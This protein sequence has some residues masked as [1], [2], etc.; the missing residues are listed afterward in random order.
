VT[1]ETI[2][3]LIDWISAHPDLS[4]VIIFLIAMTESLALVG[5]V[6]P[7]VV[8]MLSIGTLVGLGAIGLWYAI[9]WAILG[10]IAG[11]WFSYWLG[12]HFDQQLRHIWPLSRYPKLIPA[13]EKFFKRHGGKSVL[14]GR[15]V[16]P[17]R[18]I[19]PAIAGIMHMSQPKFYVMNF[20]SAVLWAPVVLLPGVAFGNS[21]QLANEVF[22]KLIIV[23]VILIFLTGILGFI[24]K[25]AFAYALMTTVNTWGEFFG[26]DKARENLASFSVAGLLIL[27]VVL[28]VGQYEYRYQPVASRIETVDYNWWNNN[29]HRFSPVATHYHKFHSEYPLTVQ[30]WGKIEEIKSALQGDQWQES[31]SLKIHNVLNYFLPH[32]DLL[33]LPAR[34]IKLFNGYDKLILVRKT[35]VDGQLMVVRFW[36]ANNGR[37]AGDDQLWLGTVYFLDLASPFGLFKFPLH[38]PNYAAAIHQ[39]KSDIASIK[40]ISVRDNYYG[41]VVGTDDW[42]G[43]VLLISFQNRAHVHDAVTDESKQLHREVIDSSITLLTPGAIEFSGAGNY[44]YENNGVTVRLNHGM[45]NVADSQVPDAISRRLRDQ[46]ESQ[47]NLRLLSLIES[48]ATDVSSRG[49]SFTAAFEMPPFG[50][51]LVY[52]VRAIYRASDVWTVTGIYKQCDPAGEALV[53]IMLDSLRWKES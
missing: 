10:A 44:Q 37:F 49:I 1:L 46:F 32:P 29:W 16:G 11:D 12:R 28:F 14:F 48:R 21:L 22:G 40:N 7:G 51:Q 39:F 3:P 30:W 18:P 4:G 33:K 43:E 34:K 26:F 25:K 36:A 17:L 24:A 38:D 53:N 6:V 41:N 2:Q 9:I 50:K 42:R 23:I 27:S 45:L 19:I 47:S 52:K 20:L 15:F 31:A 13:G 35:G 8:F 5:I